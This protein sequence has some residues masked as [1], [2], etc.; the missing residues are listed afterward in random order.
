MK[1]LSLLCASLFFVS[2]YAQDTGNGITVK[3]IYKDS[4]GNVIA[5]NLNNTQKPIENISS[6]IS[7]KIIIKSTVESETF[8]KL[9]NETS[10]VKI[11]NAEKVLNQ[12]LNEDTDDEVAI[13]IVNRTSCNMVF[14]FTGVKTLDIALPAAEE[15]AIVLPKGEYKML[16]KD[17]EFIYNS[18]RVFDRDIKLF[19]NEPK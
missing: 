14:G 12:L 3:T 7:E 19:I 18:K 9:K 6:E 16:G 5:T 10:E 13:I 4:F 1:K 11:K 17:C 8:K 2:I 15:K